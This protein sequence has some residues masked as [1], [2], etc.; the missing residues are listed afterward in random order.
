MGRITQ[1]SH[2]PI[3]K[4]LSWPS[5][6]LPGFG[7]C[8]RC[9][10]RR[11]CIWHDQVHDMGF[12]GPGSW[13]LS[14]TRRDISPALL[15]PHC[16]VQGWRSYTCLVLGLQCFLRCVLCIGQ[17]SAPLWQPFSPVCV[18]VQFPTGHD[19]QAAFPSSTG[20]ELPL[21]EYPCY[22][23]RTADHWNDGRWGYLRLVDLGGQCQMHGQGH[24]HNQSQPQ[25]R[26]LERFLW[27][28]MPLP[29]ECHHSHGCQWHA[30]KFM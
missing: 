26:R 2:P 4:G 18:S 6:W 20:V 25:V 22:K 19:V 3:P 15:H 9:P 23:C 24:C 16:T 21:P 11:P 28:S 14:I 17:P 1:T 12:G 27:L 29:P 10:E 7:D 13:N 8:S 5:V 30:I